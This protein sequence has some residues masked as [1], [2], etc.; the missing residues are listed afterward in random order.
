M[1]TWN[2]ALQ[3]CEMGPEIQYRELGPAGSSRDLREVRVGSGPLLASL[4]CAASFLILFAWLAEG[5]FR[6]TFQELDLRSRA[7]VHQFASPPLTEIMEALSFLGSLRF[8]SIAFVLLIVSFLFL[9]SR[10][11]AVWFAIAMG[12]ELL[13]EFTLKSAFHRARPEAF[14][15]ADPTGYSFPSGHALTSFCFYG[16]L[17]GL[18]STRVEKR[19]TRILVW[20]ATAGLVLAIGFSRIYL[21]VHYLTDVV[22]GYFA[23]TVWVSSLLF[24]AR[25]HRSAEKSRREPAG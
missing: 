3:S 15:G 7:F 4:A 24:V 25:A 13:L 6:G 16:V 11:H 20:I 18:L 17:A 14:F 22:A 9:A 1:L 23:G 2:T 21:G 10:R 5:V 12:G 8:L 19:S